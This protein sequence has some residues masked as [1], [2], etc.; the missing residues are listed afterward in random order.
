MAIWCDNT[1]GEFSTGS[2]TNAAE[3]KM[4]SAMSPLLTTISQENVVNNCYSRANSFHS[5]AKCH[6]SGGFSPSTLERVTRI[7]SDSLQSASFNK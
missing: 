1:E 3:L 5:V 6:Q 2:S 7:S 4:P